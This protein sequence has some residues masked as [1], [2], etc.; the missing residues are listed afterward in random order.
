MRYFYDTSAIIEIS[1]AELDSADQHVVSPATLRELEDLKYKYRDDRHRLFQVQRAL[2]YFQDKKVGVYFPKRTTRIPRSIKKELNN[3]PANVDSQ[4][5]QDFVR[6]CQETERDITFVSADLAQHII[7]T[8]LNIPSEVTVYV[9]LYETREQ[10][11]KLP[12]Y[13]ESVVINESAKINILNNLEFNSFSLP[14]NGYLIMNGGDSNCSIL[15]WNGEKMET[16]AYADI[17]SRFMGHI[18]P[19]NPEQECLFDLLQNHNIRVKV[20]L[21][22]FGTGKTFIMLAHA[23]DLVQRGKFD[24]IVYVRNNIQVKDTKDIG[25]LPNDEVNKLLPYLMPIADHVGGMDALE[26]L[27]QENVIEPIHLGFLRGRDLRRCIILCDE[28]ENITRQHAQLILGRCSEGSEV[29]FAGDLRQTDGKVFENN[30]GL[31]ALLSDLKNEKL[32]G[33]IELVKSERSEV[34]RLADNLD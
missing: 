9:K 22:H 21:G 7:A 34:A 33:A 3:L 26:Q 8:H 2:G 13:Q 6:A 4:I 29:W 20:A 32:F 27:I 16:L 19:K 28:C 23:I 12:I 1:E 18:A 5:I 24:R 25:A 11:Y 30:N 31:R 15:K 17:K 10:E 14:T